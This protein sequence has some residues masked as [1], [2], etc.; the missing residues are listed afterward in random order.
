[1]D[2]AEAAY[3][4]LAHRR[5][6]GRPY[7]AVNMVASV[8]GAISVEGRSGK[9]G[10][11]SDHHLFHYLR[12]LAD[13][14]LVGAQTVRTEHYGPPRVTDERTMQRIER[15]QA[16]LPRIAIVSRSL[17]LDLDAPL[18]HTDASRPIVLTAEI[19]D[20]GRRAQVEA[21]AEVMTAGETTVDAVVALAA[22][23]GLGAGFVLCEG[24]PTLNGE[25]ARADVLDEVCLT[26][27][28][29]LV[30]GGVGHGIV[31][32]A[33]LPELARLRLVHARVRDDDVFLRYR[34]ADRSPDAPESSVTDPHD[35]FHTIVGDLDPPM[36]I[37]TTAT[38]GER[39]GCLVGFGTQ[40]SI[41]PGRY[42]VELSKANHTYRVAAEADVVA[43]HFPSV[44]DRALAQLFGSVTGDEVDK[45]SLCDWHEGPLGAPVLDGI[46]R[47]FV[48]RVL[49][50]VDTG[51]HVAFVLAP[52]AGEAGPW[53]RQLGLQDT[54]DIEPGHPA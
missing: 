41:H 28:P 46:S 5:I 9:L 12:S 6:A 45:F 43:V 8:D 13:V 22:L 51:D 35:A 23:H 31:H 37:V 21:V 40:A 20:A 18:F 10:G 54:R 53:S 34:R 52:V 26:V 3:G 4:D 1:V 11:P 44:D 17:E 30:G 29:A 15:G 36:M 7:V 38:A 33:G 47:W 39:S 50:R 32:G 49:D 27:A 16:P 2:W 14:I 25:L 24:G 42:V 19:A 48:G